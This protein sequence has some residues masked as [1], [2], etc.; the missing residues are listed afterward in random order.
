M[1]GDVL[2]LKNEQNK[3]AVEKA[4]YENTKWIQKL[5]SGFKT[6]GGMSNKQI[7]DKIVEEKSK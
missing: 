6:E 7:A 1:K 2:S 4:K 5:F 3:L